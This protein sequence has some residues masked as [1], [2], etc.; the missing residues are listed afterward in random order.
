MVVKIYRMDVEFELLWNISFKNL[1]TRGKHSG[2]ELLMVRNKAAGEGKPAQ[3]IELTW[4]AYFLHSLTTNTE[5]LN[6]S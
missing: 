5:K 2:G 6:W 4:Y 3:G 1:L